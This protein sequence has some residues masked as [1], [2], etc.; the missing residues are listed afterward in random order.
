M[1]SAYIYSSLLSTL[2]GR[3][4]PYMMDLLEME[5]RANPT[6]P[7]PW[8][9]EIA[10]PLR[11]EQW[12]LELT[13]HPDRAFSSYI[14]AGVSHGF[15]I[16]F[17]YISH[18]CKPALRNMQSA[19]DNPKVVQAYLDMEVGLGRLVGPIQEHLVPRGAQISPF[20]VIPKTS[21]PGK[22]RLIL[23]LSSP[24]GSSVNDSIE[25]EL[26]SLQYL[27]L[28]Q[29]IRHVSGM[30][31]RA[32]LAKMDIDAAYRMVP[33][34][35]SDRLLLGMRWDGSVFFDSRLPFGLRSAPKIFSPIADALQ[36]VF[37]Q[38]GVTWVG[39]YLDD[40][41]TAGPPGSP[42]CERNLQYMLSVCKRLGVPKPNVL[43]RPQQ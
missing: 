30:E 7:P 14:I 40:Y 29:V 27:R 22:W 36:W 18:S 24:E 31:Q 12:C 3:G 9:R 26:C 43:V 2:G 39:H 5:E 6:M 13:S 4:Y 10:T 33:V 19:I 11:K 42:V 35:P 1:D 34:H 17:D 8:L 38:N 41:V 16:G 15:R 23:N 21:Q 32:L 25:P 37:E 28:D 20:G